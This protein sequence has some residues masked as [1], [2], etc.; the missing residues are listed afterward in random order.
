M[1]C[2]CKY[3]YLL[4]HTPKNFHNI[5]IKVSTYQKHFFLKLHY[6]KRRTKYYTK[7]YP[8][9]LGQNFVKNFVRYLGNGVSRKN[10]FEIYLPLSVVHKIVFDQFPTAKFSIFLFC[11]VDDRVSRKNAFEIYSPLSNILLFGQEIY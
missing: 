2:C 8:I 9:K 1:Q 4:I 10:A 5:Y 3:S 7:L 11:F 6:P